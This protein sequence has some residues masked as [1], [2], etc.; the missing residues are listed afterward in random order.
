MNGV[1]YGPFNVISVLTNTYPR[2]MSTVTFD[3]PIPTTIGIHWDLLTTSD[4]DTGRNAV[5]HYKV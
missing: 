3:D 1:G 4:A 5:V 2:K